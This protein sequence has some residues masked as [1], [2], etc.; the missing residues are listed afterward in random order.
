MVTAFGAGVCAAI[1]VM[2]GLAVLLSV[3]AAALTGFLMHNWHPARVGLGACGSLFTGFL[4]SSGVVFTRAGYAIGPSAA[5]LFCLGAVALA[6]AALVVLVR[7]LGRRPLLRRGPDHLVHR[8]RRFGLTQPGAVVVLG[9]C[10]FAAVFAGVLVHAGWA[11]RNPCSGW[12]EERPS[13]CSYSCGR[14]F[15]FRFSGLAVWHRRR[16]ASGCV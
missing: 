13:W 2:D 10:A 4:L 6:D 7:L 5:V 9:V 1:E 8:L 14:L 11:G 15:G 12:R 3:F 16:S